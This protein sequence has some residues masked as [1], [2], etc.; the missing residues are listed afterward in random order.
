EA[1]RDRATGLHHLRV[2]RLDLPLAV[3]RPLVQ[4]ER[5]GR[6]VRRGGAGCGTAG[7]ILLPRIAQVGFR[8]D[9]PV[10]R[11]RR[12][13]ALAAVVDVTAGQVGG[14]VFGQQ[15]A[16]HVLAARVLAFAEVVVADP[17]LAVDEIVRRPVVV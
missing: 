4:R 5:A 9:L 10:A 3:Q 17:A 14:A 16:D 7:E 6:G 1:Q 12:L 2:L 15:P 8:G 11:R 13:G